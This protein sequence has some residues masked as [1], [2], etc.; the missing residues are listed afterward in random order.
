MYLLIKADN[1]EIGNR[2][3]LHTHFNPGDSGL[4]LFIPEGI[5]IKANSVSNVIDLGIACAAYMDE[6]CEKPTSYYLYPRSSMGSKTP[7]RLS[8]SVGI[9]DSG[10]RGNIKII[11]DN[12]SD[13]DYFIPQGTRLVQLCDP[14]LNCSKFDMVSSLSR[15]VR[16]TSGLGSTGGS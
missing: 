3:R 11:V 16:G 5:N 2:Y 6:N 10:Y 9:I 1:D 12:I 8:N 7:L 13:E 14:S 4:D 15:T